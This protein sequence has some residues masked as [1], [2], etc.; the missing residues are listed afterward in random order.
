MYCKIKTTTA[1]SLSLTLN[2]SVSHRSTLTL[3]I[4][5]SVASFTLSFPFLFSA[6]ES[7]FIY[8]HSRYGNWSKVCD[9]IKN[10]QSSPDNPRNRN[11]SN[12]MLVS[13][14]K[15]ER[16][17]LAFSSDLPTFCSLHF[18]RVSNELS[19]LSTPFRIVSEILDKNNTS[20]YN[21]I[22][23]AEKVLC[24]TNVSR[25]RAKA[26]SKWREWLG[27]CNNT[28]VLKNTYTYIRKY[29]GK[30]NFDF[31]IYFNLILF[32]INEINFN[33]DW[34]I[35]KSLHVPDWFK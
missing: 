16:T 6:Y 1:Q 20:R 35:L 21:R 2:L 8:T 15:A 28:F 22:T 24:L 23:T 29:F 13:C 27:G 34:T 31:S 33:F 5:Y 25:V 10:T 11:R 19:V 7:D 26:R 30:C 12:K 32:I 17:F 14:A 9:E 18:Q 3:D 4:G